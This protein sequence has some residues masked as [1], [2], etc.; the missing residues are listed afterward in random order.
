MCICEKCNSEFK[1]NSGLA[2]HLRFCDG[3]GKGRKRSKRATFKER[4]GK[5]Y[6][7]IYGLDKANLI[8]LKLSTNNTGVASTPE[9]EAERRRKISENKNNLMGGY[10]K[11]S[12]RGKSGYY[13]NIWCDSSWELAW[14]IYC[15][16]HKIKFKRNTQKFEY[17][18]EGKKLHYIPDFITSKGFVEIKG[19]NS[20]QWQA[21]INAF[22]NKI[23]IIDKEKI[24]KYL[25]Y[26]KNKYG[27]DFTK[28]LER[29]A[30]G[31]K[32][33]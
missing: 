9:K 32:R 2:G 19:Y 30:H 27:L 33:P 21:K 5:T 11:G 16:D 3:T 28:L 1:N 14:V 10:R 29:S 7:E 23:E 20:K 26:A 15:I 31:D 22:E 24:K 13:K 25:D 18:F 8:K 4:K 12:G 6:E 17:Y